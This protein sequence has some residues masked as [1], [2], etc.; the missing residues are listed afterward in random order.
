MRKSTLATG[1]KF[2]SLVLIEKLVTKDRH[3]S[4]LWLCRCVCG[5]EKVVPSNKV[6]RGHS[7]GCVAQL[8]YASQ[9][10]PLGMKFGRLTVSERLEASDKFRCRMYRCSCQC[11]G[12]KVISSHNLTTGGVKSC[13]CLGRTKLAEG[14]SAFNHLYLSYKTNAERRDIGFSLEKE[15]FRQL[16]KQRCHYCGSDPSQV[17]SIQRGYGDYTYNGVDR[18]DALMGYSDCNCVACC[19]RCNVMKMTSSKEDFLA[20]V[21]L[22]A[23]HQMRKNGPA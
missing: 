5:K 2:G 14:E 12:E 19:G 22:I 13:G 16:T 17:I 11:G 3:E 4:R 20:Q 8:C 9:S 15:R 18:L 6:R 7:C 21:N 1:Q 23:E 10:L